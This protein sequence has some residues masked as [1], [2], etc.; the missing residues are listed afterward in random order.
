MYIYYITV[1]FVV[2]TCNF[3][4]VIK[5]LRTHLAHLVVAGLE[6][7][8]LKKNGNFH[9]ENDYQRLSVIEVGVCPLSKRTQMRI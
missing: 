1:E 5:Q 3:M 7:L 2:S 8:E 4:G 6:G 9:Q